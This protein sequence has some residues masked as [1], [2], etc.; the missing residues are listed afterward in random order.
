MIKAI[1]TRIGWYCL[2]VVVVLGCTTVTPHENYVNHLKWVVGKN[3]TWLRDN[4]QLPGGKFL[5][6]SKE[7]PNGN[8]EKKYKWTMGKYSCIDIYEID[9]KSEIVVRTG[10]EGAD[11]DCVSPP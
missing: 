1:P 9:P 8:V 4:H 6:N 7:L 2:V 5:V 10:F 11:E 3:W